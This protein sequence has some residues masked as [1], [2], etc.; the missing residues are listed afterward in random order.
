MNKKKYLLENIFQN[1]ATTEISVIN[2]KVKNKLLFFIFL[3]LGFNRLINLFKNAHLKS[4]SFDRTLRSAIYISALTDEFKELGEDIMLF[5]FESGII[6]L[7]NFIKE[8]FNILREYKE[9]T[10]YLWGLEYLGNYKKGYFL[11]GGYDDQIKLWDIHS[12]ESIMTFQTSSHIITLSC[13]SNYNNN[14]FVSGDYKGNLYVNDIQSQSSILLGSLENYVNSILHL[15]KFEPYNLL[16]CSSSRMIKLYELDQKILV[17]VFPTNS[18]SLAYWKND[19]FISLHDSKTK[20]EIWNFLTYERVKEYIS[21][22]CIFGLNIIPNTEMIVF[23]SG[24][25][26]TLMELK[27]FKIHLNLN[28]VN[29]SYHIIKTINSV[30]GKCFLVAAGIYKTV[31]VLVI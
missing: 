9:H 7:V 16:L 18:A 5:G 10:S 26:F 15:N 28:Y 22:D 8:D 14:L 12:T 30:N 19:L 31:E 23:L 29:S 24:K 13:L 20:I 21:P 2:S 1:F 17:G 4:K 27:N 11:S 25:K 3:H 6:L